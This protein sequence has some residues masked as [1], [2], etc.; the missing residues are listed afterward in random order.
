MSPDDR[1]ALFISI[2]VPTVVIW[3][4]AF[5]Y[6]RGVRREHRRWQA[7][8]KQVDAANQAKIDVARTKMEDEWARRLE[9]GPAL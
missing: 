5:W 4:P 7:S 3:W 6:Q 2:M 1:L 8:I 9:Q